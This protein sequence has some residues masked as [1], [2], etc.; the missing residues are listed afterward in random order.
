MRKRLS[1]LLRLLKRCDE[2]VCLVGFGI[3]IKSFSHESQTHGNHS[4]FLFLSVAKENKLTTI[5]PKQD[6][7]VPLP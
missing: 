1:K 3:F 7:H 4:T 6:T 2:R 5:G